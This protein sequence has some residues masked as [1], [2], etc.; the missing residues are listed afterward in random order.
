MIL[1]ETRRIEDPNLEW[2]RLSV[3]ECLPH[4]PH[5]IHEFSSVG[6]L[7]EF[8][9]RGL[10]DLESHGLGR[11]LRRI[12]LFYYSLDAVLAVSKRMIPGG[13]LNMFIL[14]DGWIHWYRHIGKLRDLARKAEPTFHPQVV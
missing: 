12:V 8:L 4:L 9:E 6:A 13:E 5:S 7:E 10:D 1:I 14:P 2:M 3:M 11:G